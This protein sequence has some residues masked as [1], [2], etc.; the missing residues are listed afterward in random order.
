MIGYV[1]GRWTPSFTP[2]GDWEDLRV[3]SSGIFRRH[4]TDKTKF[5]RSLNLDRGLMGYATHRR[6][7]LRL[8]AATREYLATRGWDAIDHIAACVSSDGESIDYF[9]HVF[10]SP[11]AHDASDTRAPGVVTL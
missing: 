1:G 10:Y 9:P 3:V 11:L 2:D 4:V 8:V 6:G 7:C 5:G